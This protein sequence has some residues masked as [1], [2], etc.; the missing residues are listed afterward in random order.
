MLQVG[1]LATQKKLALETMK[2][3]ALKETAD[4]QLVSACVR[5]CAFLMRLRHGSLMCALLQVASLNEELAAA[6]D[7]LSALK[8]QGR[9]WGRGISVAGT[10]CQAQR[11]I[12][13]AYLKQ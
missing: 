4:N 13:H 12:T 11:I 9:A 10:R 3:M 7:E 6:L 2:E 1:A 8:G 5:A